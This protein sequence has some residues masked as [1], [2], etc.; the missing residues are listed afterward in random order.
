MRDFHP[1]DFFNK[2]PVKSTYSL[3]NYTFSCF[4]EIFLK[5]CMMR[6]N[7]KN[8]LLNLIFGKNFVKVTV[9]LKQ[10]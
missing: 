4:H 2:N 10:L 6:G 5:W 3:I 7:D 9:L 1:I 8:A